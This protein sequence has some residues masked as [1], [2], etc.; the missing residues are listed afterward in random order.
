MSPASWSRCTRSP[1]RRRCCWPAAAASTWSWSSGPLTTRSPRRRSG[2]AAAARPGAAL[3]AHPG[4]SRRS[5]RSSCRSRTSQRRPAPPLPLFATAKQLYDKALADGWGDL[6][7]AA[8]HDL[9]SGQNPASHEPEAVRDRLVPRHR[10]HR[11]R[12]VP[13]RPGGRRR[14]AGGAGAQALGGP[15][16]TRR[17]LAGGRRDPPRPGR[18]GGGPLAEARLLAPLRYPRK[19]ICAGV[20]YRRHIA[21]MGVEAPPADW[22]PFFFLKPPTTTVVGP[23]DDIP[24]DGPEAAAGLGGR[25]GRGRRRRRP[26]HPPRA[27]PGPRRRVLRGQ[28]HHGPGYHQR[29]SVPAPPSATTGS[30][31]RPATARCRSALA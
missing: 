23:F 10:R 9:L 21:E 19:V 6:D 22:V 1:R 24:V 12:A 16:R 5:T 28:R 30:P 3:D 13:G 8:V 15:D 27:G 17:R 11:R 20:N 31:P 18:G 7:I 4:P 29:A 25:A 26:G 2:S 14:P